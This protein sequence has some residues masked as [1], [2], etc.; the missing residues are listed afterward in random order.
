MNLSVFYM[1]EGPLSVSLR[2]FSE[3]VVIYLF[4]RKMLTPNTDRR[5]LSDQRPNR[6][7]Q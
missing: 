5:M 1:L 4:L 2:F 6:G 7:V 3:E